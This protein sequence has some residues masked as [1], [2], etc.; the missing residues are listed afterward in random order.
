MDELEQNGL[1]DRL[2]EWVLRSVLEQCASWRSAGLDLRVSVNLS[3]R[4][5]D[6]PGLSDLVAGLCEECQVDP[7]WLTL[8][9][10][11]TSIMLDP[12][13]S[14]ATL[15][16]IRDLGTRIA[17]DD[18]GSGHCGLAYLKKLPVD[19]VK[20]DR[21]FVLAMA[22]DKHDAAIV[23]SVIALGHDLGLT[24]VAEGVENKGTA[25]L[26]SALG[27]DVAQ[28][29]Y[30]ARPMRAS[31]V[32]RQRALVPRRPRQASSRRAA[33]VKASLAR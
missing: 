20:I 25:D 8:E 4:N 33:T 13:R 16:A 9:L 27:C 2:T 31:A 29:F 19:E 11:E 1:A 3:A 23:R 21:T 5:L 28:G 26:L 15:A 22:V 7:G 6:N 24:V 17:L 12:S 14:I 10:T 18:F 32:S 30:F